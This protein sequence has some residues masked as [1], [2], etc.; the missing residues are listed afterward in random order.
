MLLLDSELRAATTR[1]LYPRNPKDDDHK[2][3]PSH[4]L[5]LR[6][7]VG[8]VNKMCDLETINLIIQQI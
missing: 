4:P 7:K 6:Q 3:C 1:R 5:F 2:I 8:K